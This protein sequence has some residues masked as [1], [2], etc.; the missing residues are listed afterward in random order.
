VLSEF[1]NA[2]LQNFELQKNLLERFTATETRNLQQVV[3]KV[4][5]LSASVKGRMS[6]PD[7][8]R[9]LFVFDL[10][11]KPTWALLMVNMFLFAAFGSA[12]YFARQP[13]YDRIDNDLKYRYI[14]MKGK[15]SIEQIEEL[16]GIFELNRDNAKIRQMLQDVETYEEAV[17]KQATLTEQARLKEQAANELGTK[18]KSIKDK[19]IKD[20]PK[21]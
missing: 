15:A 21:K 19:A 7:K 14:K 9:H 4:E 6:K 13:D 16:E 10:A 11:S 8:V 12:L 18:A 2:Q 3:E 5:M 17:R 20:K 1:K